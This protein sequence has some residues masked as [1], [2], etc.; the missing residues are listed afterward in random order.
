MTPSH[1][2]QRRQGPQ[3]FFF[4][5]LVRNSEHIQKRTRDSANRVDQDTYFSNSSKW[6]FSDSSKRQAFS[7]FK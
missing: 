4:S 7:S 5:K 2:L 6:I 1:H 3:D